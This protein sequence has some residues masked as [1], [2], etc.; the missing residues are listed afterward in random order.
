MFLEPKVTEAIDSGL[1]FATGA[2]VS[3]NV[4]NVEERGVKT[5]LVLNDGDTLMIGGLLKNKDKIENDKVPF[6]GDI[7]FLGAFFR[8]KNRGENGGT[9]QRELLIFLTPHIIDDR[10]SDTQIANAGFKEMREQS[11]GIRQDVIDK[12]LA[13]FQ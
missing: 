1:K 13:K 2:N 3:G 6:L 5:T 11:F 12:A 8:Y 9:K 4:K 7:P 10:N